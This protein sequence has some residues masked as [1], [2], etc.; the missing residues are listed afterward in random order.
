MWGVGRPGLRPLHASGQAIRPCIQLPFLTMP[1]CPISDKL[2][3]MADTDPR[4]RREHQV[5][6]AAQ[7]SVER[8]NP[9]SQPMSKPLAFA[10]WI[11]YAAIGILIVLVFVLFLVFHGG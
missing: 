6:D 5:P 8:G 2:S 7:R 3:P 4:E 9:P 11:M 1:T 10:G